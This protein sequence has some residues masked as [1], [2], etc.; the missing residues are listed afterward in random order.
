[1][2][3]KEVLKKPSSVKEYNFCS[4]ICKDEAQCLAIGILKCDHYKDGQASYRDIAFRNYPH[5]CEWCKDKFVD[6][7][8]VHHI[9]HNQKNNI[10]QNLIILCPTCHEM[11]TKSIVIV[12]DRR[13]IVVRECARIFV[14]SRTGPQQPR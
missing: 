10:I 6:I 14:E 11:E 4:R 5:E 3:G 1:M 12:E 2:C 13:P 8:Q 7:L 9:D